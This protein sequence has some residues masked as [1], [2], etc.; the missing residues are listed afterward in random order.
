M[1]HWDYYCHVCTATISRLERIKFLIEQSKT[2]K[3]S[4][5]HSSGYEE[6]CLQ[7]Y[8]A[9]KFVESHPT[10]RRYI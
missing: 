3:A 4:Y 6:F 2:Y 1:K 8:N 7:E 5:S 9:A 10:F